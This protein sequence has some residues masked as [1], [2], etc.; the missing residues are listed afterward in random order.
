MA[1]WEVYFARTWWPE[2]GVDRG[3]QRIEVLERVRPPVYPN[4]APKRELVCVARGGP[5][6]DLE[7][8]WF[9]AADGEPCP[10]TCRASTCPSASTSARESKMER[11][12]R[13]IP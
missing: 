4:A 2:R 9:E 13:H 6:Q 1:G 7:T 10:T 11:V 5:G 8:F 12:Q 3:G